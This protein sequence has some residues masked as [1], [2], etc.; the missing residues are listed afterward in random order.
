MNDMEIAAS[1]AVRETMRRLTEWRP[2]E[3]C[4]KA[5]ERVLFLAP[6]D[7]DISRVHIGWLNKWNEPCWQGLAH[8]PVPIGWMPLPTAFD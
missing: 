1:V 8:N 7:A 3:T 5:G 6:K 4:P 2:M